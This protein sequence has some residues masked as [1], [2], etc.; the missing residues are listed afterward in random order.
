MNTG[1]RHLNA[2]AFDT[3]YEGFF[4]AIA[5]RS[6]DEQCRLFHD[7]AVRIYRL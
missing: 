3:I 5:D 1:L 4:A 7:D 2:G 6:P